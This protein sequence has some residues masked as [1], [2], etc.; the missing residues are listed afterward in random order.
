VRVGSPIESTVPAPK[1]LALP[2]AR[3][4]IAAMRPCRAW[5][6]GSPTCAWV[7]RSYGPTLGASSG[8]S[9]VRVG[10]PT[11]SRGESQKANASGV[12]I[13]GGGIPG[14]VAAINRS[15]A[16]RDVYVGCMAERGYLLRPQCPPTANGACLP[17][18][19]ANE[20]YATEG[21]GEC[22]TPTDTRLWLP[23]CAN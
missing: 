21:R 23:L 20:S 18:L 22:R 4:F 17:Q 2:R 10:S 6:H 8:L 16:L 7:H 9:H 15:E 14:V 19:R 13:T 1:R 12:V 3:G 5:P 11:I